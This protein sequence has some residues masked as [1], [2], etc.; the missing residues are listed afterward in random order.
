MTDLTVLASRNDLQRILDA[1]SSG[2]LAVTFHDDAVTVAD[3]RLGGLALT[4]HRTAEGVAVPAHAVDVASLSGF[5]TV[6]PA[7]AEGPV[8][9]APAPPAEPAAPP[10]ADPA[11]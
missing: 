2:K 9:E 4:I 10:E 5:E 3:G 7:P 6:P 11:Q 1:C 8:V